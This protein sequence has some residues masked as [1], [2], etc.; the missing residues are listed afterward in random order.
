MKKVILLAALV[1]LAVNLP[2][3]AAS[4][5]VVVA[6]PTLGDHLDPHRVPGNG[7]NMLMHIFDNLTRLDTKG[8]VQPNIAES[9]T[10]IAPTIWRFKIKKGLKFHNGESLDAKVVKLNQ[11]RLNNPKMPGITSDLKGI[12]KTELIDDYT[13]DFYSKTADAL[14]LTAC[15]TS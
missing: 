12:V 5:E 1:F 11:E 9:W 10:N 8:D 6:V 4:T 2:V 14:S 13:I 7:A 3:F 15:R